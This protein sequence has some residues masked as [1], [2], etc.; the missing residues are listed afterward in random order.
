MDSCQN[1][2]EANMNFIASAVDFEIKS[3]G[4]EPNW[5]IIAVVALAVAGAWLVF[6]FNRKG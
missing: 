1:H 6:I 5:P 3:F 4:F 2:E